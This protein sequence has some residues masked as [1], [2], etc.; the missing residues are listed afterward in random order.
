MELDD[1]W[2]QSIKDFILHEKLT[3]DQ[4]LAKK[5]CTTFAK[6]VL[7]DEHLYR[8]MGKWSLFKYVGLMDVQYVLCEIHEG[9]C[10]SHIGTKALVNK[11]LRYRYYW[12]NTKEDFVNLVK[13]CTKC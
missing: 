7:I 12:P 4:K 2:T 13:N 10:G 6:I 11:V 9:I 3:D 8:T 5:I 1:D